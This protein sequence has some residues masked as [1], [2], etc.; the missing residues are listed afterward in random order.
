MPHGRLRAQ[1]EAGTLTPYR[2][3]AAEQK[4]AHRQEA[5][6]GKALN[7]NQTLKNLVRATRS[8]LP[9]LSQQL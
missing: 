5:L 4:E 6:E 2:V 9:P 1:R 7:N 8:L 3:C